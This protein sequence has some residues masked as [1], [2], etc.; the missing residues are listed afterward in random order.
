MECGACA[1][2]WVAPSPTATTDKKRHQLSCVPAPARYTSIDP[3]RC[4]S[5]ALHSRGPPFAVVLRALRVLR[6]EKPGRTTKRNV[7]APPGSTKDPKNGRGYLSGTAP[8]GGTAGRYK[9]LFGREPQRA[10]TC[11]HAKSTGDEEAR[12]H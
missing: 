10:P 11:Q 6:G 8:T 9:P 12:H 4:G 2:L 7:P 5:T 1:P 3:K